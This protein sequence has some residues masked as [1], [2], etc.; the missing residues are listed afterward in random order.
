ML[1]LRRATSNLWQWVR[2]TVFS[3]HFWIFYLGALLLGILENGLSYSS[4]VQLM[5]L[6]SQ[7]LT[8]NPVRAQLTEQYW[9]SSFLGPLLGHLTGVNRT[10]LEYALLH[11]VVFLICFTFL[12]IVCRY[13]Y[14][15]FTARVML[16]LFV[17]SPASSLSFML[18]GY[19]DGLTVLIGIAV[20]LFRDRPVGLLCSALL[21]GLNHP[22]QGIV[23]LALLTLGLLAAQGMRPALLFCAV[24]G[25]GLLAGAIGVQIWFQLHDFQVELNRGGFILH[26]LSTFYRQYLKGTVPAI[27]FSL[28]NAAVGFVVAY[29]LV[30]WK[31]S[32][33]P[34]VLLLL[35]AVAFCFTLVT[36][37]PT[38]VFSLLTFPVLLLIVTT[39][40]FRSQSPR[41]ARLFRTVL[42]ASVALGVLIPRYYV[43]EGDVYYSGWHSLLAPLAAALH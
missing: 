39:P 18:L 23:I 30:F 13:Q 2:T 14:G 24:A 22:E 33:W 36:V 32:R 27:L 4:P 40:P 42:I 31:K 6:F 17:L 35:C 37:D 1:N 5:A 43:N 3:I 10:D 20:V 25:S 8:R 34:Q 16:L 12:V 38:R 19:P 21:L 7:D 11:L 15:D 28:F 9:L 29:L 41:E 26:F